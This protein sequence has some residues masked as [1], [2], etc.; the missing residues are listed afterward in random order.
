MKA[1]VVVDAKERVVLAVVQTMMV[2][3][4]LTVNIVAMVT[5][6]SVKMKFAKNT[7]RKFSR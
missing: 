6:I 2:T 3:H 7:A 4:G 1:L 5:I